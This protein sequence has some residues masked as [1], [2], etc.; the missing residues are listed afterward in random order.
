M[1]AVTGS[2]TFGLLDHVV[3]FLPMDWHAIRRVDPNP[4]FVASNL[5]NR[6]CDIFSDFD[7][8]AVTSR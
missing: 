8:L 7:S 4:H 5:D 6:D 1:Y 2:I 3:D